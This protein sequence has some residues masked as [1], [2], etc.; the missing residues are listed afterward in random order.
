MLAIILWIGT[1]LGVANTPTPAPVRW[2]NDAIEESLGRSPEKK[3][4]WELMLAKVPIEERPGMAYLVTYLPLRDLE[5]LSPE[6]LAMNVTLAYQARGEVPW[7]K[8]IPEEIFLDAILPHAS[9]T[10]LRDPSRSEFH[11]KYLP[12]V[13]DC[14][15]PGDA[16]QRLNQNLFKDYKVTYNT[17]RLRTDQNS[18]ESITQG[19]ATCT[20]LSIMLV[21][22]CRAVGVPARVA[23]IGAWPGRGGNHTWVEVWDNAWHF[24][25]AAEPDANGLD[26]AWF[27]GDASKA[28]KE[29]PRNAIW[30]ASYRSTGAIFPLAWSSSAKVNGENVTDRYTGGSAKAPGKPRLMVEV[31]R[32]GERVVAEVSAIDRETGITQL[33]GK[34]LGPQ[35]DVNLHLSGPV[36]RG[37]SFLVVA[38]HEGLQSC[39]SVTVNEDTVVRL[40]LD[41]PDLEKT[42]ATVV[43]LLAERFGED[44]VKCEVARK[45]LAEVPFDD[46]VR[47]LAWNAYKTSPVHEG[48]RKEYDAKTVSTADRT[49][50]Y[51][52][53]HVG[54]K[55]KGGWGL[56]IAMHGGGNAPKQVNDGQ[57]KGMFERYY[58]DHPE[59]GGYVYLS[60]RAPNDSWNGFYD[61]AI[62]PLIERLIRQFVLIDDVD[63]DKV[64]TLGASHGGYGAFVIGPKIPDRFAAVHASASAP[65]DGETFGENLRNTR[66]TFMVGERDTAYG[67]A[68]RCQAF[69]KKFEEWRAKQGGYVGGLEWKPGVGHSVPDRDKLA[70]MLKDSRRDPWPKR[71]IWVQSDNVLKHFYW[72]EATQ[73]REGGRIEASVEG[74]TISL[75]AEKQ[76][77]LALWLDPAIVDLTKPVTITI[78]GGKTET[79]LPRPDLETYCQGLDERGDPRLSSPSRI[80]LSLAPKA[81]STTLSRLPRENLLV[82]R[83]S[84]NEPVAA[85]TIDD[86]RKRRAEIL[87]GMQTVM[88]K[89]P[90]VEKRCPL[91]MKVVEE[92]DCGSYVRRTITYAS[93]PGCR[94]PAYLLIPKELL[95]DAG[96]TAPAALCLHGTDDTVGN[97]TVVGLGNRPN[98]QYASELA[99]RGYVTLAPHYPL[100]AKY[101]PDIKALG[102]E[103]GTLKAVWDNIRGLDLL[104]SLPFVKHGSYG[105]IGHSL[106]GHN[107]VYT[108]VFDDRIKAV[109]TSCGLDSYLDYYGGD[110]KNW[111]LEKGWCQTRY[112]PRMANYRGHLQ[113]I[114]FDFHEMIGALA[115]RHVLIVSPLKD[116]NFR[117]A[118]VDR[119]VAAARPVFALYGQANRLQVEHP[120]CE[121]DFP[122]AMRQQ[123]YKLFDSV[124]RS[125]GE[126]KETLR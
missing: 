24:V 42:N 77:E 116:S 95:K 27:V 50:P 56:V 34:S 91:D 47:E 70:E 113:D 110:E 122:D 3:A 101:Q 75:S 81:Q 93:E 64:Y 21:E 69:A 68:E 83:D 35:S 74:N 36:S 25:G 11:A 16:A 8:R 45:L 119:I 41:K 5:K 111:H 49:S 114:P 87:E 97:G 123:A 13:K 104:D 73:P 20:G 40:D 48:L 94:V 125:E 121:H 96:K 103:S 59:V 33:S 98:R 61:D 4:G 90:G 12:L 31:V 108:A 126:I 57:W 15:T 79:F 30:A 76:E 10:E 120:D 43:N 72:I 2:W 32:R 29:S 22:A 107:S 55:P 6:S 85:K 28:L 62:C 106:G 7:G 44:A 53:R 118:S 86:W 54:E 105:T 60:L 18:K 65:T 26:H 51:L 112:M 71:L 37:E 89:L 14:K 52:W 63:S 124:L 117:W 39:R 109:V 99:E 82:Y 92:V 88:G 19:M 66:F 102:W 80:T 38:R 23:G 67:R 115:P 84:K 58:K 78:A 17:R 100:L 9:L 46:K 1:T